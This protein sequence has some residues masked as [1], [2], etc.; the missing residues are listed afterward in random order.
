MP[1]FIVKV[2]PDQDLYLRWSTIVDCPTHI[3]KRADL[4]RELKGYAAPGDVSAA[5][6]D[7]ADEAGTSARWP[8]EG[9]LVGGWGAEGFCFRDEMTHDGKSGN[10]WLP[11]ARLPEA[12][13]R[14]RNDFAADISDLLDPF[15]E[16]SD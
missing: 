10:G 2:A 1:G 8:P 6:F 13:E 11:R 16:E 4:L 5:A 3:G 9:P 7:R 15:E 12:S 14:W